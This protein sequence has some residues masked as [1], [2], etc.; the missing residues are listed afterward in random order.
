MARKDRLDGIGVAALMASSLLLGLNQVVVKVVNGGLQPVFFAGLRSLG[1]MLCVW[2]WMAWRG[3]P[4][5]IRPGTVPAGIGIGLMFAAEFLCLF[6][7]LDRT[8]VVRSSIIFYSMPVWFAIAAHFA[9]PGERITPAKA[10]GL[11]LAFAGVVWAIAH[12]AGGAAH[13]A[14]LTGDL[15]SL[16]AALCWAG[17]AFLSRASALREVRAEMQ[18]F[19]MV[20][21][22]GPVLLL[23][24]PLFGPFIRDLQPIHLWGLAFQIVVVVSAGFIFWLWLL[25]EYPA[26]IV[27]S[28][29]FL[30]PLLG[31]GFGWL[32]LGEPVGPQNPRIRR[33]GGRGDRAHQQ[34]RATALNRCLRRGY[35]RQD[36]RESP[37]LPSSWSKYPRGARGADGPSPVRRAGQAR[38]GPTGVA[39]E[40]LPFEGTC[41]PAPPIRRGVAYSRVA[42][43]YA[44][45]AP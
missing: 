37:F 23:V 17:L 30:T 33:A 36:E 10:L 20:A 1:A 45:P 25:A 22:S 41:D 40:A 4:V 2:A 14:N 26:S 29:S 27:A 19:W 12:R 31:I 15:L 7:A 13:P 38:R 32:L 35:L 28:F 21:V 34:R 24:S 6:T 3:R 43:A 18:L 44:R 5:R 42:V 11:G 8:T 39:P 16:G 9:L